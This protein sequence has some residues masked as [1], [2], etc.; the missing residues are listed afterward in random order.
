MHINH[1]GGIH[2]GPLMLEADQL[3][4]WAERHQVSFRAEHI[5]G[6]ANVETDCLSRATTDQ[7]EWCFHPNY[8][9]SCRSALDG[10]QWISSLPRTARNSQGSTPALQFRGRRE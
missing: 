10:Q 9:K 8:F 3:C 7:A 5:A 4:L 2:S 6:R 1:Q